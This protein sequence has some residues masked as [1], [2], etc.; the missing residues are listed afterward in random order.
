LRRNYTIIKDTSAAN[1]AIAT[2]L[3]FAG[4]MS[5]ISIM[6]VSIVPVI[7]ELEGAIKLSDA[8]AQFEDLAE[9]QVKLAQRGLPG[10]S[11]EM[12]ID[13]LLGKLDWDLE[14][15][16][17]WF[18]SS[19]KD[20]SGLSL[21]NPGNFNNQFDIKYPNSEIT[22][23]CMDDLHVQ[24]ESKWIYAI[25]DIEGKL[26]ISQKNKLSTEFTGSSFVLVH[27]E[28]IIKYKLTNNEII[29]IDITRSDLGDQSE[30]TSDVELSILLINGN[31]G[32]SFIKANNEDH[33][34]SGTIW[35]IPLPTGEN[36]I[37]LISEKDTIITWKLGQNPE[38]SEYIEKVGDGSIWSKNIDLDSPT[39]ITVES[40]NSAKLLLDLNKDSKNGTTNWPT[41]EG[42]LLGSE[43]LIPKLEGTLVISNYELIP[44]QIDIQGS[45]FSIPGN[46]MMKLDWPLAGTNGV[47]KIT[48]KSDVEIRFSK[49]DFNNEG[50]LTSGISYLVPS[51]TGSLSGQ[52][53]STIWTGNYVDDNQA[54]IYATLAGSKASVNFSGIFN[55]TGELDSLTDNS[56]YLSSSTGEGKLNLS[57]DNGQSIRVMQIIGSDGMTELIDKGSKRCL[58]L[59]IFASGWIG[60]NLP[61]YDV[62]ELTLAGIREAWENGIHH[63]G[64]NLQL[65]GKSKDTLFS[66]LANAWIIQV[67][68]MKYIFSSS[69]SN[70]EVVNKGGFVTTNHPEGKSSLIHSALDAKG[71][72]NLLGIHLPI[73]TPTPQSVISGSSKLK[74]EL[75]VIDNILCTNEKS[76]EVRMGWN[77]LY[78]DSIINW[79]SEDLEYSEDWISFPNQYNL[80]SDY[81]GWIKGGDGEAT[82]HSPNNQIDFSLTFTAISYEAQEEGG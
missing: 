63:S 24:P 29:E 49:N 75:K 46:G 65:I 58:P 64:A 8:D 16:G 22:S 45:K 56:L 48:S 26:I 66:N 27:N 18:S 33:R 1:S 23:Y 62:S 78:G 34:G 21:R 52:L 4:V 20:Q 80:L 39:M 82:Y 9:Y 10:S 54:Y 77:G 81:T 36:T 35:K 6:L 47:T 30:I 59:E 57:V 5:I 3:M 7:N 28:E 14:N 40:T 17:I 37:N 55:A 72:Q 60:V 41:Y 61:W 51:D 70:L 11:S 74:I 43:F 25:P 12:K 42:L 79:L 38:L 71:N 50:F 67:P 13:P 73:T 44:N 2:V 15:S 19:W 32:I 68:A 31:S 53:F 76:M 69:I